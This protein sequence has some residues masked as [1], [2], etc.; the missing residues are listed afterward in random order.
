MGN[1]FSEESFRE[2]PAALAKA[3]EDAAIRAVVLTGI[4]KLFCGGGDVNQFKII[5]E[6]DD[7]GIP[8]QLVEA[9]GAMSRAIRNCSKPVIAA[10]NGAAAGAGVGVALAADFRIM[11]KRSSLVTA[12]VGMG[13]PGDTSVLYFLQ[14][15][16]GT[17]IATELLM[18]SKPIKGERASEL[19]LVNQVV[20][21]GTLEEETWAFA[22]KV[23][24]LPTQTISY[25]KELFN[26]FFYSD[27]EKFN[28]REAQLMHLASLTDDHKEAVTAFLEK[29]APQ[30]KGQ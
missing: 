29:R 2:I 17:A 24:A 13:L 6:R 4:G 28:Q 19:G 5:I 7:G 22:K 9:T 1:A 12:F 25:Q 8:E 23:A 16:V 26:E 15:M 14:K 10:I 21:D 30:F 20:E 18:L 3:S 11:E 27:L